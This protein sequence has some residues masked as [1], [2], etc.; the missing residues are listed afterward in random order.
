MKQAEEGDVVIIEGN[1]YVFIKES[2]GDC[3]DCILYSKPKVYC[4]KI[5]ELNGYNPESCGLKGLKLIGIDKNDMLNKGLVIV[6]ENKLEELLCDKDLCAF[7]GNCGKSPI[8]ILRLI[9]ELQ[10]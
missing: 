1:L 8:C 6:E 4:S 3:S 7:S 9:Q 10:K 2:T 5:I